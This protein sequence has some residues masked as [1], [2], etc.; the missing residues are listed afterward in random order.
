MFKKIARYTQNISHP[1][2]L[3]SYFSRA[4]GES[5][6][7]ACSVISAF[8]V[9]RALILQ[10]QIKRHAYKNIEK[11]ITGVGQNVVYGIYVVYGVIYYVVYGVKWIR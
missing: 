6:R 8:K 7:A 1:P 5:S 2:H 3:F 9:F 10:V 4:Y 11:T